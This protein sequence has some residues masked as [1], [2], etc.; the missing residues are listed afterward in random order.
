[1]RCYCGRVELTR[2]CNEFQEGMRHTGCGCHPLGAVRGPPPPYRRIV[3]EI[4]H[5]TAGRPDE[6]LPGRVDQLLRD[7]K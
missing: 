3:D 1:M 2:G 7:R 6:T 5:L 4:A